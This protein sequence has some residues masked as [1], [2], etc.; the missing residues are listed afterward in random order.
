MPQCDAP[1][2]GH[3]PDLQRVHP[4]RKRDVVDGGRTGPGRPNYEDAPIR[5]TPSKAFDNPRRDR[6][7]ALP[8]CA[9][10]TVGGAGVGA[11]A[12]GDVLDAVQGQPD[13]RTG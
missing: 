4:A 10:A 9:V 11:R 6:G 3:E 1:A 12:E 5:L 7:R 13:G 8:R 2:P